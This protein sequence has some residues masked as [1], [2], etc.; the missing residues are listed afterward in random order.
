MF[1]IYSLDTDT[2]R[3]PRAFGDTKILL[4]EHSDLSLNK[5]VITR[6]AVSS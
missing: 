5:Q 1:F 3:E 4:T 6:E 2:R